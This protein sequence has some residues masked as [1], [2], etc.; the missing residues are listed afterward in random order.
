MVRAEIADIE[1]G[2]VAMGAIVERGRVFCPITDD[3]NQ[4]ENESSPLLGRDR[5]RC[6]C[7]GEVPSQAF[8]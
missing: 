7:C 3:C 4:V 2:I 1:H 5:S 8:I 6:K